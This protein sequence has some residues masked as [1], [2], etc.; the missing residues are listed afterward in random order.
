MTDTS[1]AE[2]V[3]LVAGGPARKAGSQERDVIV[4]L[5]DRPVANASQFT[6]SIQQIPAGS[7]I[8]LEVMRNGRLALIGLTGGERP[9]DLDSQFA[10]PG[11]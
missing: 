6:R 10:S 1:G 3:A 11:N 7:F 2:V 9:A 8:S 4:T 5:N